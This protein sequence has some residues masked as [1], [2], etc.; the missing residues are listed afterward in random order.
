MGRLDEAIAD[1]VAE[2]V[3]RGEHGD[4]AVGA[5]GIGGAEVGVELARVLDEIAPWSITATRRPSRSMPATAASA[6]AR[7]GTSTT[8][9]LGA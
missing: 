9:A 6:D 7:S 2:A 1:G 4:D 8:S 3:R 5:G